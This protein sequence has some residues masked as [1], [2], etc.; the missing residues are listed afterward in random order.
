M[1]FSSEFR[2]TQSHFIYSISMNDKHF[3]RFYFY[4]FFFAHS[5]FA[6]SHSFNG[7][8]SQWIVIIHISSFDNSV[9]ASHLWLFGFICVILTH[10]LCDF[11]NCNAAFR[12][13]FLFFG[14]VCVCC[15][16]QN[17]NGSVPFLNLNTFPKFINHFR[18][19]CLFVSM[20]CACIYRLVLYVFVFM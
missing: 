17:I 4:S 2:T 10:I 3:L 18:Q 1:L 11:Q 5:L 9:P 8:K 20:Q 15:Y 7:F 16:A 13:P 14:C 19:V 12:I 6:L